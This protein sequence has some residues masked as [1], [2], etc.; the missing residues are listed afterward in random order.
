MKETGVDPLQDFVAP[1]ESSHRD[2]MVSSVAESKDPAGPF[3]FAISPI[4][5]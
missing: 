4:I 3:N 2:Q 5:E 1:P